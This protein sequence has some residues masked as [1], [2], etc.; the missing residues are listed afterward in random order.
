MWITKGWSEFQYIITPVLD[1]YIKKTAM[2][3]ISKL[4]YYNT[5]IDDV[6][7]HTPYLDGFV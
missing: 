5:S 1:A 2:L 4:L 7:L 3:Y 6:Y